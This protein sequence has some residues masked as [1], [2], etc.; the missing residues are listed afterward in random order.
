MMPKFY[1]TI[2]F[3]LTYKQHLVHTLKECLKIC[4]NT[5]CHIP[6]SSCIRCYCPTNPIGNYHRAAT[7]VYKE[8]INQTEILSFFMIIIIH[9]F[10]VPVLVSLVPLQHNKSLCCYDWLK[11]IKWYKVGVAFS[12]MMPSHIA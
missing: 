2:M 5:K 8:S 1:I 11:S 4:L 9:N 12:G 10:Q 6:S 7:V 3:L